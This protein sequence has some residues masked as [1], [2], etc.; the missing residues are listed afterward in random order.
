MRLLFSEGPYF[1]VNDNY[2]TFQNIKRDYNNITL[3]NK[4]KIEILDNIKYIDE[5][6]L[7]IKFKFKNDNNN[8]HEIRIYAT[9]EMLKNLNNDDIEQYFLDGT[10]K[11]VPNFG[12]FKTLVTFIGFNKKANA[13]VQYCYILLTDETQNI[14]ENGG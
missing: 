6:L 10:Y 2:S 8:T 7:K 1:F 12:N 9:N 14:F 11:I 5:N 3:N 4:T 13:F